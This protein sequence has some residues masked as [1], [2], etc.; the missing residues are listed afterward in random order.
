MENKWKFNIL[1]SKIKKSNEIRGK[2]IIKWNGR[3]VKIV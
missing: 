1:I 3:K 2:K